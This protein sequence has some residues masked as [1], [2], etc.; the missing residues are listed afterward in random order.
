MNE[1]FSTAELA[2]LEGLPTTKYG[3]VKKA[4]NENWQSRQRQGRGGGLEYH[5]SNLPQETQRALAIKSTNETIKSLE[6]DPAFQLGQVEAARLAVKAKTEKNLNKNIRLESLLKAEGLEGMAKDRMNAKL[7]IIKLWEEFKKNSTEGKTA[8]QHLFA[9]AYNSGQITAPDWVKETIQ[10]ISQPSLM[11]WIKRARQEGITSLAGKYG[12][13]RYSGL[14]Y[15]NLQLQNYVIA[16]IGEF[17]HCC[18]KQVWRGICA[19]QQRLELES[20]PSQKTIA[21][22]MEEWKRD[23]NAQYE[24]MKNPDKYRAK[25]VPAFGNAS[26]GITRYLQ[27]WETDSTPTDV[28]LKDGRH[29]II[30]VIDVASRRPKVLISKTSNSVAIGLLMR[31]AILEWGVPES[32]KTDNG[33]DYVSRHITSLFE[34]LEIEQSLC[35]PFTPKAKPHIE[36]FFGTFNRD[37]LEISDGYIGHSVAERI[38][39]EQRKSFAERLSR[40]TGEKFADKLPLMTAQ[41]LQQHCDDWINN[42]YMRDK[43]AGLNGISPMDF[44]TNWINAGNPI[45]RITDPASIRALDY[46]LAEVPGG[47]G[48]RTITKNGIHVDKFNFIA[49]ELVPF[50]G[51]KVRVKYNPLNVGYI[52]VYWPDGEMVCVAQCPEITGASRAELAQIASEKSKQLQSEQRKQHKSIMRTMKTKNVAKEILQH[53]KDL[54]DAEV[55]PENVVEYSSKAL[56]QAA[57]Q[58]G[59][60]D[61]MSK[62]MTA[63][64]INAA[65]GRLTPEQEESFAKIVAIDSRRKSEAEREEEEKKARVARYEALEAV[66]FR[67]I[68]EED[69]RWRKSWEQTAECFS[70]KLCKKQQ[71]ENNRAIGAL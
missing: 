21:R 48:M 55:G 35:P 30:G 43:H 57:D 2:G 32:V 68:S 54:P 25:F 52:N 8:S 53:Y 45:R 69:D 5:I 65:A 3:I 6:S 62:P 61:A 29:T 34:A 11:K 19:N 56:Q 28:M 38:D 64:E 15:T 59:V 58:I 70:Y 36:R 40:K 66:N 4:R 47:N 39:V 12:N 33:S 18:A 23:N 24:L 27:Q 63:E 26:E 31:Q 67:G 16:F 41:E 60:I 10:T 51:E 42:V 7:E 13:R 50:I 14:F 1:W 44:L 37:C 20:I 17:P 46:L 22:F 9:F 71:E 49:P